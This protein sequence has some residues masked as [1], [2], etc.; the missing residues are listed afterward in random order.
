MYADL[1]PLEESSSL[2]VVSVVELDVSVSL[3]EKVELSALMSFM[4]R[5]VTDEV[6]LAF[7]EI[8]EL[9]V[10]EFWSVEVELVPLPAESVPLPVELVPLPAESVP[11]LV[12]L[13]PLM[14]ES[15]LLPVELVT[16]LVESV[17]LLVELVPLLLK[18]VSL[19]VELVPIPAELVPL[20]VE[21]RASS[22]PMADMVELPSSGSD[23]VTLEL[24]S[25]PMMELES[26]PFVDSAPMIFSGW[27]VIA[28]I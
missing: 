21:L 6:S 17:P 4:E 8:V 22:S 28:A 23:V 13:M 20:P 7:G 26:E 24:E 9:S 5:S 12:E 2:V 15:V 3:V 25:T 11:L 1:V 18:S 16:L 14:V 27:I 19:V 10:S